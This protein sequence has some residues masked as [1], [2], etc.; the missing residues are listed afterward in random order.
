MKGKRYLASL[1]SELIVENFDTSIAE[2]VSNPLLGINQG[3]EY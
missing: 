3:N 1:L 2:S